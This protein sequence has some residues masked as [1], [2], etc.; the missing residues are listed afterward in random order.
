MDPTDNPDQAA[1]LPPELQELAGIAA[2]ADARSAAADPQAEAQAQAQAAEMQAAADAAGRVADMA[3]DLAV[4]LTPVME[5]I[6]ESNPWTAR[7]LT[8]EW[9]RRHATL[10]AAVFVK[11]GWDIDKFLS[12]EILLAGSLVM[13]GVQLSR[14]AKAYAA[15]QAA[16]QDKA[17]Q[18]AAA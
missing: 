16:Q 5:G 11:R 12:P 2:A 9:T 1:S 10:A 15:W 6:R 7:R 8:D 18:P 4:F 13:T 17:K 14:D 3:Q